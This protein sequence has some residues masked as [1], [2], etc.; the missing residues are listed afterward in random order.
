[1][2]DI[3][4]TELQDCYILKPPYHGDKRGSFCQYFTQK[5][6]AFSKEE[7]EAKGIFFAGVVQGNRSVS[8][9]GVV[10]GLHFQKDPYCQTKIVEVLIGAAIDVVVDIRKGSP[11]YGK[12]IAVLL[13]PYDPDDQTSGYQLLVPRGYA[14]GFLSL[15][16][17]TLF[18]YLVDNGYNKE[19]EG[20][21]LW[22]DPELGIDWTGMFKKYN[23]D[24]PITS[25]KDSK[26]LTLSK[27]PV[28]FKYDK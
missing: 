4:K 22:N 10:R 3:V 9:K 2:V 28:Y 19:S 11:T 18:H 17:N 7:L 12:H 5:D 23:I 21:I 8:A 14:H 24:K 1:M 20:G 16:D 25:E 15:E 6:F 26:H 13:K 27:S